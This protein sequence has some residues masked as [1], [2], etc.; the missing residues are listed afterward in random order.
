MPRTAILL[1]SLLERAKEEGLPQWVE[2]G[3]SQLYHDGY[4]EGYHDGQ[5]DMKEEE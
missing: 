4:K 3:L 2:E 5:E 1:A